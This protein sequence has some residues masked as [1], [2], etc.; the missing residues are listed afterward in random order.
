MRLALYYL[1]KEK[2]NE[3][4]INVM[5]EMEKRIPRSVIAMDYRIKHDISKILYS[6]G[7]MKLYEIYA[8]EVI[9]ET[10]KH[11][12]LN[13]RDLSSWYNPYDLL[14]THY[15]NLKMYKEAVGI[16]LQLQSY[17]PGDESV[18]SLLNEFRKK[19]GMEV[20]E[21]VP[22]QLDKK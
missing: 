3:K 13:P 19:A 21:V 2:S 11:L 1:Y 15:D 8:R 22:K 9:E 7:D 16:L 14:L 12:E 17:V 18:R 4:T 6:A 20:S 10:K 5:E